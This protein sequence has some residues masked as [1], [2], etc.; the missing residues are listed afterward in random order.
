MSPVV[1]KLF[2]AAPMTSA[3][4]LRASIQ[5]AHLSA[6]DAERVAASFEQQEIALRPSCRA[7]P[8]LSA[9][10]RFLAERRLAC[11][12][13]FTKHSLAAERTVR[14]LA[15]AK[16]KLCDEIAMLEC[17]V[18]EHQEPLERLRGQDASLAH[19][20]VV[21]ELQLK[22]LH[23]AGATAVPSNKANVSESPGLAVACFAERA[24]RVE[25]AEAEATLDR[26][27]RSFCLERV[28]AE[29]ELNRQQTSSRAALEVLRRACSGNSKHQHC[30]SDEARRNTQRRVELWA[31]L[32]KLRTTR[33]AEAE[34]RVA[35]CEEQ[36]SAASV[37]E[38]ELRGRVH[39][40]Q[41]HL[42]VLQIKA[43]HA[44][45]NVAASCGFLALA[46]MSPVFSSLFVVI[47]W[48]ATS[49]SVDNRLL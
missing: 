10:C 40:T 32:C 22:N 25:V 30:A 23:C 34:R 8:S 35:L 16:T 48:W 21:L 44:E 46:H 42:E 41:V 18:C 6:E 37:H 24:V 39:K 5:A 7:L 36:H 26:E 49:T 15:E 28:A 33:A 9:E 3:G 27:M 20:V 4:A 1:D 29:V 2:I 31:H 13:E 45:S 43:L 17:R 38:F 47:W 12:E 11:C 14:A 19:Q